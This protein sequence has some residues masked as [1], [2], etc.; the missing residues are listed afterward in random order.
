[1]QPAGES[2]SMVAYGP[3]GARRDPDVGPMAVPVAPVKVSGRCCCFAFGYGRL[4]AMT[5]IIAGG[6]SARGFAQE[7][8]L[9]LLPLSASAAP[10]STVE[11][12][13]VVVNRSMSDQAFPLGEQ[14]TA[15]MSVGSNSWPVI[16]RAENAI[17]EPA[18]VPI[19]GFVSRRYLLTLPAEA[20][21]RAVLEAAGSW[22]MSRS[23]I[24]ITAPAVAASGATTTQQAPVDAFDRQRPFSGRL[25]VDEPMYLIAGPEYPRGKFQ[26][27]FKYRLFD[28]DKSDEIEPSSSHTLQFAYTQR[29]LWDLGPFYDTSYMPELMYQWLETKTL[30][31]PTS[32]VSWLGLESGV[33]H[34]SNG[35]S[36][37]EERSVNEVY[38]RPLFSIGS[39]EGWHAVLAPELY[40]YVGGLAY[41]PDINR[42]RGNSAL[43]ATLGKGNGASLMLTLF[44]GE[45][46][47]HGSRQ[48]DLSVPVRIPFTDL[49]TYLLLQYYDGYDESLITYYQHT[50]VY[51]VGLEFVR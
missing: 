33:H 7:P 43:R 16:L 6:F 28:F 39:P 42:Y 9:A 26:I 22:G 27:S 13:V 1:M 12:D 15:T 44:P 3:R 37:S 21:G 19:A 31:S 30:F 11:I 46:F 41:N 32:G 25:T 10:A 45:H 48:W 38:V 35:R 49:R 36:G 2:R 8:S 17:G 51:R 23:V 47:E 50:S 29:S 24:D 4:L 34:E 40:G 20:R 18:R 5:M 14:F